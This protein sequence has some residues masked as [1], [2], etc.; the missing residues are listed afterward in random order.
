MKGL[1]TGVLEVLR[2][3]TH[4]FTG[5]NLDRNTKHK[6]RFSKVWSFLTIPVFS[7]DLFE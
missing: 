4:F 7:F 2:P 1:L 3:P 5:Q 6:P